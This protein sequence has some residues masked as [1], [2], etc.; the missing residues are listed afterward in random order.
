MVRNG[1][2]SG[3]QAKLDPDH[4]GKPS[5]SQ[6]EKASTA[7]KRNG[8]CSLDRVACHILIMTRRAYLQLG[9]GLGKVQI[10]GSVE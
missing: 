3:E 4:Q 2:M 8:S 5:L 10:L 1:Q 7:P 9:G 6:G